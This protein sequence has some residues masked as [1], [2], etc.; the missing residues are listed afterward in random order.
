MHHLGL[1]RGVGHSE[2]LVVFG[3]CPQYQIL[4][5]A[6]AGRVGPGRGEECSLA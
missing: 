6:H 2:Q 4:G 3:L 1:P 5:V